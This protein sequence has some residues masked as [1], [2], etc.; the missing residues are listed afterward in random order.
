MVD[1]SSSDIPVRLPIGYIY[2]YDSPGKDPIAYVEKESD[3]MVISWFYRNG[4]ET[5]TV[6][7]YIIAPTSAVSFTIQKNSYLIFDYGMGD[8]TITT[9]DYEEALLANFGTLDVYPYFSINGSTSVVINNEEKYAYE[10]VTS[11]ADELVNIDTR[12]GSMSHYGLPLELSRNAKHLPV[13]KE[14]TIVNNG[15]VSLKSGRPELL[16]AYLEEYKEEDNFVQLTFLLNNNTLYDRYNDFILHIF[17]KDFVTKTNEF[18]KD[19]YGSNLYSKL[20]SGSKHNILNTPLMTVEKH[21]GGYKMILKFTDQSYLSE[22][23]T[24]NFNNSD[25]GKYFYIAICDI[26]KCQV[27]SSKYTI[28]MQNRS[29]I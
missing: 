25:E 8:I 10:T 24:K 22:Y 7:Q 9:Y 27:H 16:K 17:D 29:V 6:E 20:F 28:G 5:Y 4:F 14:E 21:K 3:G 12:Y 18:N 26:N 11:G 15:I 19:P 13:F 23:N 2:S 1:I